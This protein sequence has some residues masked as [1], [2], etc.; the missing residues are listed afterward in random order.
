MK[1]N[2]P[3]TFDDQR[4]FLEFPDWEFKSKKRNCNPP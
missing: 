2:S 4:E 3:R 1:F